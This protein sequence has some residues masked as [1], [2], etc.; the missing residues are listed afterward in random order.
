[1]VVGLKTTCGISAYQPIY[2]EVYSIQHCVIKF[3]SD[4]RHVGGFLWVLSVSSVNKTVRHDIAEILLK[5]SLS[6][7][8]QTKPGKL[9]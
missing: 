9:Y 7:I 1:M 2:D 6:N 4:L 5:V 8:N 3:V